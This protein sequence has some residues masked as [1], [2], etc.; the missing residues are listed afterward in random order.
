M[1]ALNYGEIFEA[2]SGGVLSI[3]AVRV[4]SEVNFV[5]GLGVV[6]AG[7]GVVGARVYLKPVVGVDHLGGPR[8]VNGGFVPKQPQTDA[9]KRGD[10]KDED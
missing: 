8:L 7:G 10:K 9:G 5:S 3:G 1:G 4:S 2:E 6:A